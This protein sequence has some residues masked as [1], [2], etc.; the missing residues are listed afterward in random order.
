[1]TT[2]QLKRGSKE[3]LDQYLGQEGELCVDTDS[4][5]LRCFD[6]TTV[7]GYQIEVTD[8]IDAGIIEEPKQ[9]T[10]DETVPIYSNIWK[11]NRTGDRVNGYKY[12]CNGVPFIGGMQLGDFSTFDY[13]YQNELKEVLLDQ[14]KNLEDYQEYV[15][16]F[17]DKIEGTDFYAWDIQSD[18]Q[19]IINLV[20]DGFITSTEDGKYKIT[21]I[22]TS[23][24]EQNKSLW[25]YYGD[26]TS[27]RFPGYVEIPAD[28]ID[29]ENH[30]IS[31]LLSPDVGCESTTWSLSLPCIVVP[32]DSKFTMHEI[33]EFTDLKYTPKQ[34]IHNTYLKIKQS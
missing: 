32:L 26:N 17:I 24:T 13:D 12:Y 22:N 3:K 4:Y 15:E 14:C 25:F 7:G 29:V 20:C 28:E 33:S 31:I 21:F 11:I 2:I 9:D 5:G 16:D 30:S 1:M 23:L 34:I 6:G 8:V 10:Y 18:I 19:Y 27:D